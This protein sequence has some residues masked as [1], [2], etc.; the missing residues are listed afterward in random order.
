MR[1]SKV[2][3]SHQGTGLSLLERDN[4]IHTLLNR[5]EGG[6]LSNLTKKEVKLIRDV[7][8]MEQR[9]DGTKYIRGQAISPQVAELQ[10][11]ML[12]SEGHNVRNHLHIWSAQQKELCPSWRAVQKYVDNEYGIEKSG[13]KSKCSNEQLHW[14]KCHAVAN[15][16]RSLKNYRLDLFARTSIIL[17]VPRIS[18]I[19]LEAGLTRQKRKYIAQ[20]RFDQSNLD[21]SIIFLRHVHLAHFA[22]P[23][24]FDCSG[25]SRDGQA[26]RRNL[27]WNFKGAGGSLLVRA[28]RNWPHQ[29]ITVM[30][31]L[32]RDG[33]FGIEI[34]TGG[35]TA[36][37]LHTYMHEVATALAARGNDALILD[38]CPAHKVWFIEYFMNRR[39]IAVV[40]LPRYW[41][42]WNPIELV[43]N[44][45]KDQLKNRSSMLVRDPALIIEQAL[46]TVTPQL[47]RKFISKDGVYP[48]GWSS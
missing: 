12:S 23:A 3:R 46:A 8:F 25:I 17:S 35:T 1:R 24:F 26:G 48:N 15:P 18:A 10:I 27:G 32:D 2:P 16:D 6:K 40:F 41:P 19:L 38:N 22:R 7:G 4:L 20:Q 21:Y 39:G 42:E 43:W 28:L 36:T 47:A 33:V 13:A 30:S 31:M 9:K 37:Y 45:M 44:W 29:N 11:H 5:V 34:H 14:L